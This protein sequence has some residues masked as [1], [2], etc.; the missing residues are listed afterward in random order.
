MGLGITVL[1]AYGGADGR[2]WRW[3]WRIRQ[4][5]PWSG[6]GHFA[7]KMTGA[8]MQ[9][10][11]EQQVWEPPTHSAITSGSAN[12][13]VP[14]AVGSAV[15]VQNGYSQPVIAYLSQTIVLDSEQ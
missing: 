9:S 6:P 15:S 1:D 12:H 4:Q 13:N 11:M 10:G 14:A 3:H 2:E 8:S 7:T 5:Q